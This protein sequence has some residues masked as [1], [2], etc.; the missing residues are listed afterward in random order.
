M[1]RKDGREV[2]KYLKQ[3]I[4]F[5]RIP[6]IVFSTTKNEIEVLRCY[7]LGANTYIRKPANYD[8]LIKFVEDIRRYWIN[9]ALLAV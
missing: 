5:K 6:I 2:L 8:S 9:H 1:P 4:K 7:E 3:H